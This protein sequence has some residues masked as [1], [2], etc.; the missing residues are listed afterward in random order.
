MKISQ[1]FV[2]KGPVDNKTALVQV[3]TWCQIGDK[4]LLEPMLSRIDAAI[5]HHQAALS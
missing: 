3:L 2:P 5:W 1:K 4:P